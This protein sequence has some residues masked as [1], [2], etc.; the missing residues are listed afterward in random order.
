MWA[1]AMRVEVL[2]LALVVG[3]CTWAFRYLPLRAALHQIRPDG[4]L[5]RFFAA[6]GPAVIATLFVAETMPFLHG[7]LGPLVAGSATVIAIF[8][9]RKSVVLATLAGSLS[10][11]IAVAVLAAK[12]M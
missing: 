7:P 6:T 1:S 5:G 11:G 3:A 9:W 8:V 12:G 2:S 10:Y 4:P